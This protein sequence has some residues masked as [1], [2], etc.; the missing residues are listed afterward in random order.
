MNKKKDKQFYKKQIKII[1]NFKKLINNNIVKGIIGIMKCGHK[2]GNPL[3][4]LLQINVIII[5][6]K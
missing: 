3:Y 6:F 2:R 1:I 4:I 5:I